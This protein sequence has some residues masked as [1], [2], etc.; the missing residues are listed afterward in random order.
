MSNGCLNETVLIL[1]T[2][3]GPVKERKQ[4]LELT[5]DIAYPRQPTW[6]FPACAVGWSEPHTSN[7]IEVSLPRMNVGR[8]RYPSSDCG[9]ERKR[10]KIDT[11]FHRSNCEIP[12]LLV[13]PVSA[14][15]R[16]G[17]QCK[18]KIAG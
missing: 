6:L 2:F 18:W 13:P 10:Q 4:R 11:M 7:Q 5:V 15:I 16:Q 1:E 8:I 9:I 17:R 3:D 12:E 14:S